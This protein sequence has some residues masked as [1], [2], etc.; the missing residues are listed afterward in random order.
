MKFATWYTNGSSSAAETE[1]R[2]W[3]KILRLE[4]FDKNDESYKCRLQRKQKQVTK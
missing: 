4:K 1:R 2:G 3:V